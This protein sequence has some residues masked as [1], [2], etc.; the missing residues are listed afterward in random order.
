MH[1]I[2]LT[3][4]SVLLCAICTLVLPACG[5]SDSG[6]SDEMTGG[7]TN[8]GADGNMAGS[9]NAGASANAGS[10]NAGAS[11]NAGSSSGGT[12]ANAGSSSGGS[13]TDGG[14]GSDAWKDVSPPEANGNLSAVVVNRLTGEL[15]VDVSNKG[16]WKS[17]NEGVA[18][19]QVDGGAVGGL[20]VLGPAFDVD[21]DNP[22]RAA[23]WSLD[24]LAAWTP[25]FG[26][27]WNKMA[28]I[29]RNWDFG[30][31]DWA[32]PDAKTKIVA[33][34]ESNGEVDLTTDGAMTWNALTVKVFASGAGFPPPAFA[35]VG[36]MAADTLV[37][38][39]GNGGGILRSTDTGVS[40]KKVSDLNVRTRVPVLFKGVF[41]LGGDGLVVSKDKGAT[42][43]A[44][45]TNLEIWVGPYFGKDENQIMVANH[46]G[47][48]LTSDAGKTWTQSAELPKD[49]KYDPEIFGGFAWDPNGNILY[50]ACLGMPLLQLK[51]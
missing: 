11:A 16:I 2:I 36:V 27:T 25:D 41:Y 7:Q 38:S 46:K 31:T 50:A 23:V 6:P 19:K 3:R 12:S 49:P 26:T 47:V 24:G 9:S 4:S 5:S 48:Y 20:A 17:T 40:F 14:L 34:H 8:G 33:R 1:S 42:W 30:S 22:Q 37:Y 35:M 51:L 13:V 44:Q 32:S 28:S 10:S 18:W 29:G 15:L 43:E 39:D 45:G 21:Q